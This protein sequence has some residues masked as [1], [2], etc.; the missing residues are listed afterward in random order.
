MDVSFPAEQDDDHS[1]RSEHI[2]P[3]ESWSDQRE[4]ASMVGARAG[5]ACEEENRGYGLERRGNRI[6]FAWRL[7]GVVSVSTQ[8]TRA[9][10]TAHN[11][12]PSS[13]LLPDFGE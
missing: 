11:I 13:E 8:P 10:P 5:P 9:H 2:A 7:S 6:S 3:P 12:V 1:S 4:L